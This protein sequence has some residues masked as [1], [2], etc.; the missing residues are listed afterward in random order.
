M[1]ALVSALPDVGRAASGGQQPGEFAVLAGADR[2]QV[3]VQAE[4]R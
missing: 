4:R 2:A 3:D 1:P